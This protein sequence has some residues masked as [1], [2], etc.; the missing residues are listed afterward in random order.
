[1]NVLKKLLLTAIGLLVA[2]TIYGQQHNNIWFRGTLSYA[3]NKK[4]KIDNEVQH[5]RQNGWNNEN[6][7][8]NKLMFA[9]R[10]W[11]HYQHNEDVSFSVSPFAYFSNYKIIQKQADE[12]AKPTTEIRFSAAVDMLHNITKKLYLLDRTAIEYRIFDSKQADITRLRNRFGLRYDIHPK[13]KISVYDEL[14]FNLSGSTQAHFFDHDRLG[15]NVAYKALSY[16]KFDVGYIYI[17]RLPLTNTEKLHEH[18]VFVN[19][20]YFLHKS[21]HKSSKSNT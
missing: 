12:I 1:M 11:L 7:F 16:I 10:I 19:M 9:Y 3:A 15:L 5:R 13:L 14:L 8:D 4:L 6:L 17:S 18:N 20:T 21:Q 2:Q